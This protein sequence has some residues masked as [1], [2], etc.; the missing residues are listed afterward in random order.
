MDR[1]TSIDRNLRLIKEKQSDINS[2]MLCYGRLAITVLEYLTILL[3][4]L[5][6]SNDVLKFKIGCCES[7]T[8]QIIVFGIFIYFAFVSTISTIARVTTF[9]NTYRSKETLRKNNMYHY[10][11]CENISCRFRVGCQH[12][13]RC[14]QLLITVATL[15]TPNRNDWVFVLSAVA[16][17]LSPSIYLGMQ[18]NN[19]I[20]RLFF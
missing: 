5:I 18:N 2:N 17:L 10:T 16:R 9:C 7:E 12:C 3:F 11:C 13:H 1:K 14:M 4:G 15:D 20:Q 6:L 19:I 8:W